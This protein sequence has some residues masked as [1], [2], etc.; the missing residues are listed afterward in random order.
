ME[1]KYYTPTIDEFEGSFYDAIQVMIKSPVKVSAK[2]SR[3]GL[4][5]LSKFEISKLKQYGK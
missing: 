5:R 1:S 4:R 2:T 3:I